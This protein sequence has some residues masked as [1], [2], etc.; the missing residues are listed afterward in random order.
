MWDEQQRQLDSKLS[1]LKEQAKFEFKVEPSTKLNL[2]WDENSW[3]RHTQ[4]SKKLAA[5][6]GHATTQ[7][8]NYIN[9]YSK[10]LEEL[11]KKKPSKKMSV[12]LNASVDK[13]SQL[14]GQY[15]EVLLNLKLKTSYSNDF[16]QFKILFETSRKLWTWT[17]SFR[18]QHPNRYC[19]SKIT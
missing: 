15:S 7:I 5:V 10:E 6:I 18:N 2:H 16:T 8:Q 19:S 13:V 14:Y 1:S 9:S 4:V 3:Q 17:K 12:D 11:S